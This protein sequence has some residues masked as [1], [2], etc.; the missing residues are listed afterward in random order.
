MLVWTKDIATD[1]IDVDKQHQELFEH[2]NRFFT[3]VEKGSG[4]D[5]LARIAGFLRDYAQFH[6]KTEEGYFDR[7]LLSHDAL[8]NGNKEAH[9]AFLRDLAEFETD[10]RS[11]N[12]RDK[13]C[14][15]LTKWLAN[16]LVL[17][18]TRLDCELGKALRSEMPFIRHK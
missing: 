9:Q 10:I 4:S 16:W 13:L 1:I 14:R 3:A 17:H 18:I 15:E 8:R 12:D 11:A 7:L 6:F 5:E 2:C